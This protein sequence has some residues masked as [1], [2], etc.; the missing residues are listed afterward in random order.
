MHA[1]SCRSKA[2]SALQFCAVMQSCTVT[3]LCAVMQSCAVMHSIAS[4][5]AAHVAVS[6]LMWQLASSCGRPPLCRQLDHRTSKH[7][8]SKAL[9]TSMPPTPACS[10]GSHPLQVG[11]CTP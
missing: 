10:G 5:P 3:Q 9:H 1:G 4:M 2:S 8:K 6:Q 11:T 7:N